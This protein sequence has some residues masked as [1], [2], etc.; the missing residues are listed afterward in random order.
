MNR[1][2]TIEKIGYMMGKMGG[3]DE[4][5]V[6]DLEA[7]LIKVFV[8]SF[9]YEHGFEAPLIRALLA[10]RHDLLAADYTSDDDIE[11]ELP[12]IPREQVEAAYLKFQRDMY[13]GAGYD[14]SYAE[15]SASWPDAL[16]LDGDW[17][18]KFLRDMARKEVAHHLVVMDQIRAEMEKRNGNADS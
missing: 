7:M 6:D 11:E 17:D 2:V 12:L 14:P 13:V 4:L 15:E 16:P 3:D 1:D 18:E 5:S 8:S 10:A 9:E